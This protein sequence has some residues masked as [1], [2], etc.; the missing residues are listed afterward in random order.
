MTQLAILG[1]AKGVD[2]AIGGN[3][4][5]VP[6]AAR[7]LTHPYVAE[8]SDVCWFMPAHTGASQKCEESGLLSLQTE[9][10]GQQSCCVVQ[11]LVLVCIC[12]AADCSFVYSQHALLH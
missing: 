8:L 7:H 12:C 3:S 6:P 9:E 2:R 11:L 10:L 5:T 1:P 4:S